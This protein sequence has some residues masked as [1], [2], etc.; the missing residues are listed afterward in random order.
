MAD[1]LAR[2]PHRRSGRLVPLVLLPL[3]LALL[4]VGPAYAQSL[5]EIEAEIDAAWRELEPVIEDYNKVRSELKA[6]KKLAEE[7]AEKIEP[8][9]AEADSATEDLNQ[10][11]IQQYKSGRVSGIGALV[12]SG[13]PSMFVHRLATLDRLAR[14][15]R[16]QI[17]QATETVAE[18]E[19]R[20]AEIDAL[21][22]EQTKQEQELAE[23]AESIEEELAELERMRDE[24]RR[25]QAAPPSAT[26]PNPA[27]SCPAVA[28]SGPGAVAAEF[29]CAQQGKPYQ[30][31]ASGPNGYDCSGL[32]QA[33]WAAAGVSLT[34][35]TGAQWNEGVPV[36]RDQAIPGDLVFFYSDLSHVGLYIGNGLMVD[37]PHAG[38]VVTVRSIDT[39]PIA[40][41]RRPG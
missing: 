4:P 30:W 2:R 24:A 7:L 40:G 26:S 9:R 16:R 15:Q 6:N 22:E 14:D 32:T 34:H 10:I 17:D 35:H 21:I 41:F 19:E 23:K 25:Q 3:L 28:S 36:S 5:S 12:A 27:G 29:A 37:A 1:P 11:A 18:Y 8:L 33:A 39:M 13:S 31:G 38:A 20:K